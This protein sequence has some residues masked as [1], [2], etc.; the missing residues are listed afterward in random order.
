MPVGRQDIERSSANMHMVPAN[1]VIERRLKS[2]REGQVVRIDGWL[3]EAHRGDGF[4]WRSSLT[5]NDTGAG[6][7]ELIF[8]NSVE[9]R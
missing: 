4:T 9:I 1:S 7:C 3:V 6:A 8:V 5:R 2:V